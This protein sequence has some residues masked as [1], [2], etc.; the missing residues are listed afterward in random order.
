MKNIRVLNIVLIVFL[1]FSLISCNTN[2]GSSITED[3][4]EKDVLLEDSNKTSE[5]SSMI[6]TS[7]EPTEPLLIY[8]K[9]SERK[10]VNKHIKSRAY[11][12]EVFV[13]E[14]VG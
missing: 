4:N 2:N 9:S 10:D 11:M 14:N 12:N 5:Q 7:D 1:I 13:I 8:W 3:S 6:D